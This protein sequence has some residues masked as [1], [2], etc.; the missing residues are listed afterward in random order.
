VLECH[1]RQSSTDTQS[2]QFSPQQS[3][4][5][6]NQIQPQRN[7]LKRITLLKTKDDYENTQSDSEDGSRDRFSNT[8]P[9][10]KTKKRVENG[11]NK[12]IAPNQPQQRINVQNVFN[13]LQNQGAQ[14]QSE[15]EYNEPTSPGND[16]A[17]KSQNN[18][19][20]RAKNMK[21]KLGIEIQGF[22]RSRQ[23]NMI[24]STGS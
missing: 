15:N 13:N 10:R 21:I 19:P 8:L 12:S 14:E 3:G 11:G 18:T 2:E 4:E 9:S 20:Q 7:A 1:Q 24:W 23:G 5:L 16:Q 22:C 6:A 17:Q